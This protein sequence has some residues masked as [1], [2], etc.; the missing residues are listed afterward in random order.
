MKS[1]LKELK[2]VR[3]KFLPDDL[4]ELK[5]LSSLENKT[6]AD[7]IRTKLNYDLDTKHT[8]TR[9]KSFNEKI[10]IKKADPELIY[11]ISKIGAN[12]NQIAK[13]QNQKKD[14]NILQ[15]LVKI[16]EQLKGIL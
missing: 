1:K 4:N 3:I 6:V 8:R 11:Q 7:Y 2:D 16:E 13:H 14:I 9:I 15:S 10:I 5:H 12:L